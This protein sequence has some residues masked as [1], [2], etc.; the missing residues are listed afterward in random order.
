MATLYTG[1]RTV[2]PTHTLTTCRAKAAPGPWFPWRDNGRWGWEL[3]GRLSGGQ[4][5]LHDFVVRAAALS[6]SPNKSLRFGEGERIWGG[7]RAF[8]V[9]FGHHHPTPPHPPQMTQLH[10]HSPGELGLMEVGGQDLPT[11]LP[12]SPSRY[13]TLSLL[14]PSASPVAITTTFHSWGCFPHH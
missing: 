6:S 4:L 7:V 9:G 11:F 5:G 3:R 14:F 2:H 10:K 1:R 12:P 8:R 13:T